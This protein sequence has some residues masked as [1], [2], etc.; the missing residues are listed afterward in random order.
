MVAMAYELRRADGLIISDDQA[1]L[2]LERIQGWLATS[3]WAGDRPADVVERSIRHSRTFGVYR[4]DGEQVALTRA[5]TDLAS[6]AWLADVVVDEAHRGRGI[7]RWLV[8]SVVE[9]LRGLGV[10]RFVLATRDAH[11]VYAA[12]GFEPLRVPEMWME[13]DT[14]SR[15]PAVSDVT[16]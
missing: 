8:G 16:G 3:Y 7:G 2:D 15:R 9:H 4:P 13:F 11:G 12:L 5:M 10:P 1:R 6:F 14:R